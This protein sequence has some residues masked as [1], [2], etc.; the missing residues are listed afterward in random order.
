[1]TLI[2]KDK[3]NRQQPFNE[4][5]LI[6]FIDGIMKDFP[7]L[8]G[9]KYKKR[10]IG[11]VTST[12]KIRAAE[13]TNKLILNALDNIT[14]DEP[15]WTFVAS[16]IFLKQ[17]YKEAAYNR[18]YDAEEKY[19]SFYGLLKTLGEK[20]VYSEL[21]LKEYTKEEIKL[22]ETF[23]V[24]EKDKLFTYIGLRTLVDR[25]LAKDYHKRTFELPQERMVVAAMHLMSKEDKSKRMDLVKEAY[26][27]LSNHYMTLATPTWSNSGKTSGQLSSCFID[28][29][30]DSLQGIYDSNT[31]VANLSKM[32]GGIG[33][34]LGKIRAKG[35]DIRGFKGASSGVMPWMKQLNNTAV[36][37]DQTGIRAGA[38]AAYL[39]VW[40]KD[41]F[42]FLEAKLNNGDE[43]EKTHDLFTG[44][45]VPDLFM[46]Q[47]NKRGDWYLFCPHEVKQIMGY[48]L[49][50]FFDEEKGKGQFREKYEECVQNNNLSK[51]KVPAIDI[52]KAI[53]ISQLETGT[54]YMFYR[55]TV[56]RANA[57]SHV[58]MIYSSN[59]CV[60][61]CQNMSATTVKSQHTEDGEIVIRK[62]AGDFVVCNL[63]SIHLG[64][65]TKDDVLE[66]LIPIQ[67]RM[68]DNVID[69]N[70]IPV[71][72][73]K[74]TNNKFRGI[75]LGTFSWAQLLALQGIVWESDEAVEYSDKQYEK[76]AYLTIK[77]SNALAKEKEPYKVFKG[78]DFH[79]GSYFDKRGYGKQEDSERFIT[80]E[81][82]NELKDDVMKNG[83]R[84]GYLMAVAP[85][86]STSILANGTASIDPI[87]NR[88]F[89]EEKKNYKIPAVV[90]DL[91][92]ETTW[93][94]NTAYKID[95]KWSVKQVAARQRHI[96]QSQSFNLY[97][98]DDIAAVE[99]LDIQM[100][101]WDEG[102]KTTYYVRSRAV[103]LDD[104]CESCQ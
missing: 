42:S 41:I 35:S 47:V 2:T 60:E 50:D 11:I 36:S 53:M 13:I 39:D 102:V 33:V 4:E 8:D 40:H 82:W 29:V 84:N 32:S 25:Y 54:P 71:L 70:D 24:P 23:I 43:R 22:A 76:I 6:S 66:R 5:R 49:E 58:G 67:V 65:A 28:T 27:A 19:G 80:N 30:D 89:Y 95:Q 38:I 99:L 37:V 16:R 44:V 17:L 46:E 18:A 7:N 77:A 69:L 10:I 81:Q 52:F 79:N 14:I 45:C 93:Y 3:G 9:D 63:S 55:D 74:I 78:S 26:W 88:M 90:P 87:F 12:E 86:G 75:G 94:Y 96:D 59:L 91:N 83:V 57:N 31:D 100:S 68:L 15:N 97:V 72:Q 85:N 73:A 61:I 1:M 101:A 20:K 104:G 48:A 103:E 62:E 64:N 98:A 51:E 34:Y 56:N 21:I 92:E